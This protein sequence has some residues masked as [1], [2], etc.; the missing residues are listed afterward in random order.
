MVFSNL[1]LNNLRVFIRQ[2]IKTKLYACEIK[3]D[4]KLVTIPH[5]NLYMWVIFI[6]CWVNIPNY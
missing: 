3:I 5:A 1:R 6:D 2:P 4:Y